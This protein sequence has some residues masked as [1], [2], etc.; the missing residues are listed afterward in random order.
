[1]RR[2]RWAG[3]GP[4]PGTCR[5]GNWLSTGAFAPVRSFNGR[6]DELAIW[7]RALSADEV[8]AEMERGWPGS[9]WRRPTP[10]SP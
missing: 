10:A 2:R 7:D 8:R 3:A 5:I 1:M 6:I 9:M 4:W